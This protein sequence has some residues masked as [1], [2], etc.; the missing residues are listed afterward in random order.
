MRFATGLLDWIFG[1]R[2]TI[3]LPNGQKRTVTKHWLAK[4]S[5]QGR[6]APITTIQ[7]HTIGRAPEFNDM[8][9]FD[10][11]MLS[12]GNTYQQ[13]TWEIGKD[14]TAEQAAEYRDTETGALYVSY[15][16][17]DS[18]WKGRFVT[19]ELFLRLKAINEM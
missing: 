19:R 15:Q 7:V 12:G 9:A 10:S 16:I 18:E 1:E 2:I 6:A 3:E 8:H 4:M 17:V 5:Q 14:V 11:W 13:E